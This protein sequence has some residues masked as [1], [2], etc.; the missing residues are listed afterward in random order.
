M[1]KIAHAKAGN[2][3]LTNWHCVRRDVGQEAWELPTLAGIVTVNSLYAF[4]NPQRVIGKMC[5]RLA[6]FT[7]CFE[8]QGLTIL[9]ATDTLHRGDDDLVIGQKPLMAGTN[10]RAAPCV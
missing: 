4:K 3:R 9:T 8:E 6:E 10:R 5:H 7:K 2:A 1:L